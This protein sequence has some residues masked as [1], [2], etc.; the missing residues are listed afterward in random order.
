MKNTP[1]ILALATSTCEATVAGIEIAQ[2]GGNAFDVA[3]T[4]AFNLLVS[5][6]LMC[7]AGG[8]GF[9]SIR[10]PDG[11]VEIIDFFDAMPGK[12]LSP[13]YVKEY[14]KPK[15]ATL[16]MAI[17]T[18][19]LYGH[20]TAGV[21]GVIKG[22]EYI[23]NSYGTMPLKEV[24]Q[25][26]IKD[27]REGIKVNNSLIYIMQISQGGPHWSNEYEINILTPEKTIP[28]LG[29]CL[30]QTDLARTL[31]LIAEKG[32][33]TFYKGEI[34]DAIVEE[35]NRG[36]G[37]ITYEDLKNYKVIVR[38]PLKSTFKKHT[39]YTNPPPSSGGLTLVEMLQMIKLREFGSSFTPQDRSIIAK[40]QKQALHDK[41]SRYIDPVTD[42]EVSK[43]MLSE[44]YALQMYKKIVP[45]P[46]TT[47]LSCVDNTGRAIGITMSMGY[48]SG[49]AIPGTGIF[50]DNTLGELDLNPDG[51]L[52][53]VPG[54]RLKSGMAPSILINEE[55]KDIVVLG[56]AGASR[57]STCLLQIILNMVLLND[58]LYTAIC[59]SRYHY[60]EN[61]LTMEPG[62]E[63][64][65]SLLN[66]NPEYIELSSLNM[67]LG[68]AHCAR[69]LNGKLPEAF[70]DPRR[71]GAAIQ[72][73]L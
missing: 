22:L 45:S 60:E 28:P 44:D 59:R 32:S 51:Y 1:K 13:E 73:V 70:V 33:D 16:G 5:N 40:I 39:L 54:N 62:I 34:A 61:K 57:I 26:A 21:P 29:Y 2:A 35:M 71:S 37:L 55:N 27:A 64:D 66:E 63:I 43:E 53:N 3:V 38:E 58:D 6:V 50:M 69:L 17:H 23:L 12:G 36:G 11:R 7:S 67:Y 18:E 25:P 24:M 19:T 41:Y 46:H 65:K 52:K 72:L 8:G 42:L 56:T 30:K 47:H 49:A 10:H 20:P 68:G 48:D 15:K 9:A 14:V 31:E 4:A